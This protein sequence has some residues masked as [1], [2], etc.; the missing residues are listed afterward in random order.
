MCYL[1]PIAT[2][3]FHHELNTYY[4]YPSIIVNLHII[5]LDSC[6]SHNEVKSYCF[7]MTVSE[8]VSVVSRESQAME[9]SV[10]SHGPPWIVTSIS[11]SLQSSYFKDYNKYT[12]SLKLRTLHAYSLPAKKFPPMI[13]ELKILC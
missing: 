2:S 7:C 6:Q 5:Y 13:Y 3:P 10:I 11:V 9:I 12:M 8:N 4:C 1:I